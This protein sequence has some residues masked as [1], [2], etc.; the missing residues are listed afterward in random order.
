[1]KVEENTVLFKKKKSYASESE[2]VVNNFDPIEAVVLLLKYFW[3]SDAQ[4]LVCLRFNSVC[5]SPL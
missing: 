4:F 3:G 5:A 2:F 1:M